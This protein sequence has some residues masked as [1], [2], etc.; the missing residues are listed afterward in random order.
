MQFMSRWQAEV[1][2]ATRIMTALLYTQH[3]TNKLLGFPLREGQDWE[4]P[5]VMSLRFV[6]GML[7]LIGGP[8]IALGLWTRPLCFLMSGH[9]AFAYFLGHAGE[10]FFPY[11]NNGDASILYCF[12]FLVLAAYGPGAWAIDNQLAKA[13]DTRLASRAAE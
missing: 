13:S 11:V 6:S 12:M 5:E 3:G 9:M 8:I 4:F 10:S 7:E 2:G 1:L